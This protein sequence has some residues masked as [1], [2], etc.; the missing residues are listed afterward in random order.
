MFLWWIT[1]NMKTKKVFRT[2]RGRGRNTTAARNK[3]CHNYNRPGNAFKDRVL[4]PP[5]LLL[6]AELWKDVETIKHR[7]GLSWGVESHSSSARHRKSCEASNPTQRT[8]NSSSRRK[9]TCSRRLRA[10]KF[11]Y[12]SS[13]TRARLCD[14]FSFLSPGRV[15]LWHFPDTQKSRILNEKRQIMR[16]S[17]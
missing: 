12:V 6:L 2:R 8:L 17:H 14:R 10:R 7:R 13:G 9:K 5:L 1:K 16:E 3:N 4:W 11:N 15:N